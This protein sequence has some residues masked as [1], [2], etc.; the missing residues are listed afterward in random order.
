MFAS[1]VTQQSVSPH[2]K[3]NTL[4][5]SFPLFPIFIFDLLCILVPRVS[6][7]KGY[8]PPILTDAIF[9]QSDFPCSF[10]SFLYTVLAC[11][12]FPHSFVVLLT[13]SLVFC[14]FSRFF[15]LRPGGNVQKIRSLFPHTSHSV[16]PATALCFPLFLTRVAF[17]TF[18]L[19]EVVVVA[20]RQVE[21]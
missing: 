6:F 19:P 1:L 11:S 10:P 7:P 17:S 16:Y 2:R 12:S 21:R 8:P 4:T 13:V 9:V 5:R 18:V 15:L 3:K 20:A 14:S